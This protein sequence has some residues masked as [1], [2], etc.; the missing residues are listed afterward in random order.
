MAVFFDKKYIRNSRYSIAMIVA[1]AV[2]GD[3]R[4]LKTA[5]SLS[6][7]GYRVH[8]LGLNIVP[9]TH[10]IDGYPFKITLIANPRF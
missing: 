6:K 10:I 3:S 4:V 8:I 1:N 9:E 7:H 2:Q 5:F